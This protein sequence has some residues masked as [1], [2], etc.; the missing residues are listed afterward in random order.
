M[1][2]AL[3]DAII[4]MSLFNS[5]RHCQWDTSSLHHMQT[6]AMQT[7][8]TPSYSAKN[9]SIDGCCL[10]HRKNCICGAPFFIS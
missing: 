9:P 7:P 2:D 8:R 6:L 5:Y 1:H 4:S 10:G 3:S